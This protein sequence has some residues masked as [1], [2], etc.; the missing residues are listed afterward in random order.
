MQEQDKADQEARNKREL[1][2]V[3]RNFA[4]EEGKTPESKRSGGQ[5]A[6]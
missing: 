4:Q 3:L 1:N 6:C 2:A 5:V